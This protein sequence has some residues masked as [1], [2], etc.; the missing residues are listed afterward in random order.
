MLVKSSL[1][2]VLA[3]EQTKFHNKP[4]NGSHFFLV[5]RL[6]RLSVLTGG[7]RGRGCLAS[8][9][10][11]GAVTIIGLRI[12]P[13]VG[14]PNLVIL[15]M[16]AVVLSALRWG[17][18]AAGAGAVSSAIIFDYF[19]VPRFRNVVVSDIWYFIAVTSLLAVGYL[20]GALAVSATEEARL[21]RKREAH[22][23][24]VYSLTGSLAAA[25]GL[26]EILEAISQHVRETFQWPIVILLPDRTGLMNRFRSPDFVSNAD[27]GSAAAWV[28]QN[29]QAAGRGT[30]IFPSAQ[31]QYRPLKTRR[32]TVGV[33]GLQFANIDEQPPAEQEDLLGAFV[34]QAALAITR[35]VLAEEAGRAQLLQEADKL[36]KALLNS[37]S[38]NLR[39]PLASVT[40]S[41]NGVLEDGHLLD[42]ATQREL[43]ETA[44]D[45][46]RRLDRLLQNL[47]DMTRLEGGAVRVKHEPCDVQ[48]V[49]GAALALLGERGRHRQISAFVPPGLP[50]IPMDSVLVTQVIVN[51]LD[52]A[53]KYS[54]DASPI[55]IEARVEDNQ[56][57]ICVADRGAGI[58]KD[59]CER[60]FEKFYRGSSAGTSG[61]AGLGLSISKGFIQAHGGRIWAEPRAQ[62]GTEVKFTLPLGQT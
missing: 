20:V 7:H 25:S 52:N 39:T 3:N 1:Q 34:N 51:L 31:A 5:E 49:F 4:A 16:L 17:R 36:Q 43:L 54:A 44:Y 6:I 42:A 53:L 59:D 2:N 23:A 58:Q 29:G 38:H 22:T 33:L 32:G 37:I 46:S 10:L 8:L 18:W 48:D 56:L 27:D 12:S 21:A 9:T 50:L 13:I 60:V 30:A 41:L 19:F 14:G 47:L 28:L 62:G 40:G 24:S 11:V 55:E 61:G 57:Q 26:E 45:E 15:Y 35:A